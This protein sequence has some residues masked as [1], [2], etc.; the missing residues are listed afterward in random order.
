MLRKILLLSDGRD[1][2][3][4]VVQ[5]SIKMSLALRLIT[6]DTTSSFSISRKMI[7]LGHW[8]ES[9]HAFSNAK[10]TV[11]SASALNG[12]FND[13]FDDI[14][15]LGKINLID[16]SW[17]EFAAPLSD[18][19]WLVSIFIDIS[20]TVKQLK[21]QKDTL[22]RVSLLKLVCDLIFCSI[23]VFRL[24]V[25]PVWQNTTGLLAAILGTYKLALKV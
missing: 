8:L 7:R 20:Q 11:D 1:K 4:K 16:P 24:R 12:V 21:V 2:V 15:C 10:S 19:L 18:R 9:L 6:K 14:V 23:D 13:V 5:Y 25:N 17:S 3:L 22:L